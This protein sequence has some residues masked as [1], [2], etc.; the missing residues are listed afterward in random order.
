[1]GERGREIACGYN[2]AG[3][4]RPAL[5]SSCGFG[6]PSGDDDAIEACARRFRT[7]DRASQTYV[8]YGGKR[9]SCPRT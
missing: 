9:V 2:F 5:V 7:Y 3:R 1:M 6:E 4:N 8:A